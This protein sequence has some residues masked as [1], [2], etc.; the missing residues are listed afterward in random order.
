MQPQIGV[1]YCYV[2]SPVN[3]IYLLLGELN[4]VAELSIVTNAP[5]KYAASRSNV[6]A[7][8]IER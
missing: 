4:T 7:T 2:R 3:H 6:F 8:R 5:E 1:S